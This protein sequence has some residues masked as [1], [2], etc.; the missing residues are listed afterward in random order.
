MRADHR[1]NGSRV[2]TLLVGVAAVL[3]TGLLAL[4][5]SAGHL[6]PASRLGTGNPSVTVPRTAAPQQ[7][8]HTVTTTATHSALRP[9]L[10]GDCPPVAT[11]LKR[12]EAPLLGDPSGVHAGVVRVNS[13]P[14]LRVLLC[15]WLN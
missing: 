8:L 5:V 9:A 6:A 2:A 11:S 13:R 7:A 1:Q 14:P 15:T 3:A 4:A 10:S 12:T